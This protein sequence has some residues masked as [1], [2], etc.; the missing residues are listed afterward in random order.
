MSVIDA[1]SVGN[2]STAVLT[3]FRAIQ[4]LEEEE[5]GK[6]FREILNLI[7]L[8]WLDRVAVGITAVPF[9]LFYSFLSLS[10]W[11]VL[12]VPDVRTQA[13]GLVILFHPL[14]TLRLLGLT[15]LLSSIFSV[16]ERVDN[17]LKRNLSA[18]SSLR[19]PLNWLVKWAT[20]LSLIVNEILDVTRFKS[21]NKALCLPRLLSRFFEVVGVYVKGE[22]QQTTTSSDILNYDSITSLGYAC[23]PAGPPPIAPP[24]P[25][26]LE[27]PSHPHKPP[28]QPFTSGGDLDYNDDFG[29]NEGIDNEDDGELERCPPPLHC[30]QGI[31]PLSNK[32]Y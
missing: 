13:K 26:V 3:K 23:A 15:L 32:Y 9:P 22:V 25:H 1:S 2:R 5:R 4:E 12:P 16:M 28:P 17:G 14:M 11:L 24:I 8:L 19:K 31:I 30:K 7:M 29:D 27:A 20:T 18:K 21:A 10:L 6:K